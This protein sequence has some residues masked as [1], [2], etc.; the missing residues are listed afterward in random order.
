M[1]AL[2]F[3]KVNLLHPK[4]VEQEVKL[5]AELGVIGVFETLLI[6]GLSSMYPQGLPM[7]KGKTLARLQA[8]IL[9][10]PSTQTSINVED[11]EFDLV[12]QVF[13]GEDAKFQATQY[14][15]VLQYADALEG[16]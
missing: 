16:V 9:G 14:G 11:A 12:K 7:V 15:V 4:M 1:K 10:I 3:E 2:N 5:M 8:R 13:A 6:Q